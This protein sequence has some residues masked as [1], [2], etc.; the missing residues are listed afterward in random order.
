MGNPI[1]VPG[2]G[3]GWGPVALGAHR[4]GRG[5]YPC[6]RGQRHQGHAT[7][8]INHDRL[9]T[10]TRGHTTE[11]SDGTCPGSSQPCSTAPIAW[12]IS[13]KQRNDNNRRTPL[14][15]PKETGQESHAAVRQVRQRA[16][17]LRSIKTSATCQPRSL[18]A[19]VSA[20]CIWFQEPEQPKTIRKK[21]CGRQHQQNVLS[22]I[23]PHLVDL[24]ELCL[25]WQ[26]HARN[27]HGVVNRFS[28]APSFAPR[29]MT[30]THHVER[31]ATSAPY[32]HAPF[33]VEKDLAWRLLLH[34]RYH[35]RCYHRPQPHQHCPAPTPRCRQR[36]PLSP[37]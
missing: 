36:A 27:R 5:E 14:L 34:R 31:R 1:G 13:L 24:L 22:S 18:L 11:N 26:K 29:I 28:R 16:H 3:A 9:I 17:R 19:G 37:H 10:S 2:G 33:P 35:R 7:M 12:Q 30:A 8:A 20:T 32:A 21:T 15:I 25:Q 6:K 23:S 4:D